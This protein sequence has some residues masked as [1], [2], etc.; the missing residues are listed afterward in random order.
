MPKALRYATN[1]VVYFKGDRTDFFYILKS[2]KVAVSTEEVVSP[3][4]DATASSKQ[5]FVVPGGFFGAQAFLGQVPQDETAV[6]VTPSEVI[7]FSSDEFDQMTQSNNELV[8]R[9]LRIFSLE[10]TEAHR[11]VIELLSNKVLLE[12]TPPEEGFF[13]VASYFFRGRY[14]SQAIMA[15]ERYLEQYPDGQYVKICKERIAEAE[16]KIG[17]AYDSS[18][19][20]SFKSTA[21]DQ[22]TTVITEAETAYKE[23]LALFQQE[24]YAPCLLKFSRVLREQDSSDYQSY[25]PPSMYYSGMAFVNLNKIEEA[26]EQFGQLMQRYPK[27]EKFTDAMYQLASCYEKQGDK[28]RSKMLYEK[29]LLILPADSPLRNSIKPE[30]LG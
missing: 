17:T 13:N 29:L 19:K 22:A 16:T 12:Q 4:S 10:M 5:N 23:A 1:S 15:M 27:Y 26:I 14:Y 20:M 18:N 21:A 25:I 24:K 7:A 6:C 28:V 2:G 3:G 30:N 8:F 11:R 9:I